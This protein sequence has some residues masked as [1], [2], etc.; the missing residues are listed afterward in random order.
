MTSIA[1]N[2]PKNCRNNHYRKVTLT[3]LFSASLSVP[4][5]MR[6]ES[7]S[8]AEYTA[9]SGASLDLPPLDL[10]PRF[11]AMAGLDHNLRLSGQYTSIDTSNAN[12]VYLNI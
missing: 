8:L 2:H 3:A 10:P 12:T 9:H 7:A 11:G 1:G 6:S 5:P 4:P